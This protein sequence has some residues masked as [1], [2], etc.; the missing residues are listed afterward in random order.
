VSDYTVRDQDS[1]ASINVLN[2]IA[3]NGVYIL[4]RRK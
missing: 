2:A 3:P 1:S 4:T